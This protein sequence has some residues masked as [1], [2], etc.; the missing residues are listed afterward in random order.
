MMNDMIHKQLETCDEL[1]KLGKLIALD[2]M[3]SADSKQSISND[4]RQASLKLIK[5]KSLNREIF[6]ETENKRKLVESKKEQVDQLLLFYENLKYKE[7]F[8]QRQIRVCRDLATPSLNIIEKDLD[9]NISTME[10]H[11]NTS[12]EDH[13][14]ELTKFHSNS[15]NI[16]EKEMLERNEMQTQ[17]NALDTKMQAELEKLDKKRKFLDELPTRISLVKAATIDIQNQ[18]AA[19]VQEI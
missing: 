4:Y 2:P 19:A 3:D 8:L 7:C 14:I 12:D 1:M 16:L 11:N 5:L 10:F 13:A 17:L 15:I 9:M 18:F 6:I